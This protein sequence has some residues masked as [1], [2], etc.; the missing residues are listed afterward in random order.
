MAE[1]KSMTIPGHDNI[2]SAMAQSPVTLSL[3]WRLL[4]QAMTALSSY[5]N[6]SRK[7]PYGDQL[8]LFIL[9]EIRN[10]ARQKKR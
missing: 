4:L 10:G 2:I 8:V 3:G 5:G 1:N 9:G 7:W 6:K